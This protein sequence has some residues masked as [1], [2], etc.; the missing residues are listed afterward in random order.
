LGATVAHDYPLGM[1]EA[2][3]ELWVLLVLLGVAGGTKEEVAQ[4]TLPILVAVAMV[5]KSLRPGLGYKT[6]PHSTLST[7]FYL[8][9][10]TG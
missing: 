3:G 8:N 5:S 6:V 2:R 9:F 7:H 1:S 4:V 10:N